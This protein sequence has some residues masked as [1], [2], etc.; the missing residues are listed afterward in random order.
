MLR[1]VIEGIEMPFT[2][3]YGG[4]GRHTLAVVSLIFGSP[5]STKVR[6]SKWNLYGHFC[7]PLSAR[8]RF[9]GERSTIR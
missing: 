6:F 3:W 2:S 9:V 5:Q 1:S 7:M 8:L 4:L